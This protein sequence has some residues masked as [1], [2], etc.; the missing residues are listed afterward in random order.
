M[1][2]VFFFFVVLLLLFNISSCSGYQF[3]LQKPSDP[4]CL[5]D[6]SSGESIMGYY[7]R[8]VSNSSAKEHQRMKLTVYAQDHQEV[9]SEEMKVGG[10]Y[11]I[12]VFKKKIR[13]EGYSYTVCCEVLPNNNKMISIERVIFKLYDD[14]DY[15]AMLSA[16]HELKKRHIVKGQAVYSYIDAFGQMRSTLVDKDELLRSEQDVIQLQYRLNDLLQETEKVIKRE[17]YLRFISESIFT[18]I[19]ISSLLLAAAIAAIVRV[20]YA[21]LMRKVK[22]RF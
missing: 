11:F 20:Q 19:W 15:F 3:L 14:G 7:E 1:G 21:Y 12:N 8:V 13:E 5:V 2:R 18:R 6:V 17:K 16:K 22:R 4:L 9:Y 10:R